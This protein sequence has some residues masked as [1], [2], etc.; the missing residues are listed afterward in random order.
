MERI[1][2]RTNEAPAPLGPYSQSARIGS[3]VA[4]AGQGGF[5][6]SGKLVDGDVSAQTRQALVNVEAVLRANGASLQ[7]VI[8]VGVFLTEVEDFADMNRV[9]SEIFAEPFPARTTVYV[10][11]PAGMRIEIDA[12][13]VV[14]S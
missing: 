2:G 7:E 12:L 8:R 4:A 14:S 9:Y 1:E 3:L 13:A 5:D 11:L 6:R 10:G